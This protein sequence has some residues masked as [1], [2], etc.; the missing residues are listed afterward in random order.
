[1]HPQGEEPAGIWPVPTSSDDPLTEVH[2]AGEASL[3]ATPPVFSWA[4]EAPA[5]DEVQLPPAPVSSLW[6]QSAPEASIA[7]VV[8]ATAAEG[9]S[10]PAAMWGELFE[11]PVGEGAEPATFAGWDA[12]GPAT[13]PD[14]SGWASDNPQDGPATGRWH[15]PVEPAAAAE[16]V[17]LPAVEVAPAHEYMWEASPAPAAANAALEEWRPEPSTADAALAEQFDGAPIDTWTAGLAV[18]EDPATIVVAARLPVV[19]AEPPISVAAADATADAVDLDEPT[20]VEAQSESVADLHVAAFD[21]Q[22]AAPVEPVYEATWAG[23][24]ASALDEV[25]RLAGQPSRT[26]SRESEADDPHHAAMASAAVDAAREDA[27]GQGGSD[28]P[29][30]ASLQQMLDAVRARRAA[31]VNDPRTH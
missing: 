13:S 5:A 10:T 29:T 28:E 25:F 3:T 9:N 17:S 6:D 2:V 22:E 24:V 27:A 12:P 31:L 1:P 7:D 4:I 23:S 21:T 26:T 19:D 16:A 8:T 30:L 18:G 15:V 20:V 11:E 14:L